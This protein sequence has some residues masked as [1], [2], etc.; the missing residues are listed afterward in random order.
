MVNQAILTIASTETGFYYSTECDYEDCGGYQAVYFDAHP[1]G[2]DLAYYSIGFSRDCISIAKH[3]SDVDRGELSYFG[4]GRDAEPVVSMGFGP[5]QIGFVD[6]EYKI[7]KTDNGFFVNVK[8]YQRIFKE[9]IEKTGRALTF[10][11]SVRQSV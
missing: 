11:I 5:Y 6:D 3:R 4:V 9:K 8:G 1:D 2:S 10:S 7:T